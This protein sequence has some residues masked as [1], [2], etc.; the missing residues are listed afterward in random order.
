MRIIMAVSKDEYMARDLDDDMSWLGATDKA[1]FRILTSV[2]GTLGVSLKSAQYM[3]H[4]L[5]GRELLPLSRYGTITQ[6][7]AGLK[8]WGTLL[9]FQ[10]DRPDGW[11]IGGP[12]LALEALKL[13]WV[14]EIHLCHSNRMAFPDYESSPISDTLTPWLMNSPTTPNPYSGWMVSLVTQ[15]LDVNVVM[16]RNHGYP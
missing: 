11:L 13:G 7:G 1:V 6:K 2:G 14:S 15:I 10:N 8:A 9:D 4:S 12:S 5:E 16:W 3:P